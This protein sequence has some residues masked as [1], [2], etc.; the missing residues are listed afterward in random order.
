MQKHHAQDAKYWNH[1]TTCKKTPE[2]KK[3][4]GR[5]NTITKMRSSANKQTCLHKRLNWPCASGTKG[6]A[7]HN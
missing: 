7:I 5:K 4:S 1:V 2:K 3:T 6:K